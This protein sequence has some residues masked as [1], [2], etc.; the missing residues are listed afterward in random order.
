MNLPP[1]RPRR[2]TIAALGLLLASV[3]A[4]AAVPT[5]A[6]HV[7]KATDHNGCNSHSCP[8][9]GRVHD[10]THDV[11]W[12]PDHYCRSGPAE[13]ACTSVAVIATGGSQLDLLPGMQLGCRDGS[14][15]PSP[16]PLASPGYCLGCD[17]PFPIILPPL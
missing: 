15:G 14:F 1:P 8:D 12:W 11:S 16:I 4:A 10:H 3:A 5:A 13:S 2:A 17:I 6:A 9:D 7:C